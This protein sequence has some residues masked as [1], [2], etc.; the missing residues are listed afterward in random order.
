MPHD[1]HLAE[2]MREALARHPGVVEKKMF[3]GF[4]WMLNGNMLSGVGVGQFMFRVGK[5]LEAE[6]LTKPGA[7]PMDINGRPMP[8]IVWV[9][10]DAALDAGLDVWITFAKRFVGALPPK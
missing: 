9:D 2:L 4:C 6:A 8:G 1:P 5:E 7:R 10:A 3:G